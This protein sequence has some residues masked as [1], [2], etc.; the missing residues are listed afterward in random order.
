MEE[1]DVY[2]L[3]MTTEEMCVHAALMNIGLDA[4]HGAVSVDYVNKVRAHLS[5]KHTEHFATLVEKMQTVNEAWLRADDEKEASEEKPAEP[6][7]LEDFE[8]E[9]GEVE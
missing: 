1:V 7:R 4:V 3:E 8:E 2:T 5:E 6:H 9:D